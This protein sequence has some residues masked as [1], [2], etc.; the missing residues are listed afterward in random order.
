M[1]VAVA[2]PVTMFVEPGPIDAR[3]GALDWAISRAAE[4]E[5]ARTRARPRDELD[6]ELVELQNAAAALRRP[7]W[8]TVTAADA[9][10]PD[11]SELEARC[12]ELVTQLTTGRAEV[13]VDRLADRQAAVER[14]VAALEAHHGGHDITGDPAAI[15]DIQQHLLAHL[16]T[17]SAAGPAGDSVPVVLDEV[18]LLVPAD[19]KW[20]LLDLLH[21]SAERH[22]LVYLSDDAF[23]AAW[24]R[25]KALDGTITLL[26]LA[27]ESTT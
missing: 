19:R 3:V 22:Q 10:T 15:A 14:R 13:D 11:I 21:Q 2:A 6:A 5:E 12:S 9:A 7:E 23:V 25:Q 26:E 8:A 1:T 17:A 4:R 24:A 16:A 27:P 20:D 18:F